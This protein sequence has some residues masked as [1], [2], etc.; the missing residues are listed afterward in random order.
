MKYGHFVCEIQEYFGIY[1]AG[2]GVTRMI[3]SALHLDIYQAFR[4]NPYMFFTLPIITII[5]I[6]QAVDFIIKDKIYD[7]I[8]KFLIIY[9]GGAI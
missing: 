5:T 4:W 8:I 6:K 2:C 7:W 9:E 1:C 3:K